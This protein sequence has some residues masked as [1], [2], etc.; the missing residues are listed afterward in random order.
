LA[1]RQQRL[2]TVKGVG[3]QTA[4]TLLLE[5]PEL[6]A[7]NRRQA[8]ALAGVAPDTPIAGS[9]EDGERSLAAVARRLLI[10]LN[11]LPRGWPPLTDAWS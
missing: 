9:G 6:G 11:S 2:R 7:M 5:M 8:A 4:R 3:P 10:H 1:G